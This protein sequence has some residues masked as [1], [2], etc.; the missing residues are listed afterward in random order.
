MKRIIVW[1]L[2]LLCAAGPLFRAAAEDA[3]AFKKL[4]VPVDAEYVDLGKVTV[5]SD[6]FGKFY[7]FL[8]Q[9]PRL[10]KVDMFNTDISRKNID[11]LA[12][13]YPHIEFGWT[14]GVG[15]RKMRTDATAF[16][17]RHGN[18]SVRYENESFQLLRYCRDLQ[19]LDI[20]HNLVDDLSF[21]YELP[22]LKVLILADNRIS[23]VTPI[24]SLKELQ[25]LEL[26]GNNI[27]D[28][29]PLTALEH[30]LDLNL[31]SNYIRDL[32]PLESMTGLQRL[33]ISHSTNRNLSVPLD[34]EAV[35]RL[36]EALPDTLIDS[37][38]WAPTEGGWRQHPRYD[39]IRRIFATCIGTYEPFD[40]L[41]GHTAQEGLP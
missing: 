20:G 4:T 39:T 13:R 36:R 25:Y 30:L 34:E 32:S 22:K 24:A 17:T 14:M 3:A 8:D 7:Q 2:S 10:K 6:Q 29:T 28:V 40:G 5:D 26:F 11:A 35:R 9:L 15:G 18:D 38:A 12:S 31:C 16:S 37:T 19:A 41:A 1:I 27:Q 21:L 33:W 23:D